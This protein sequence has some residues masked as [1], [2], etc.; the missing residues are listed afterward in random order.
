MHIKFQIIYK[1][2]SSSLYREEK[3]YKAQTHFYIQKT[4]ESAD[5]SNIYIIP[6]NQ[7]P[8]TKHES[9][10]YIYKIVFYI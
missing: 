6:A 2:H 1:N 4:I 9:Q 3:I 5:F 10:F 8:M 7:S